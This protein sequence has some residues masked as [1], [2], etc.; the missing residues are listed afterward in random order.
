[1]PELGALAEH[2]RGLRRAAGVTYTELALRT[3][4]SAAHLKR[5]ASGKSLPS[6]NLVTAYATAC[7]GKPGFHLSAGGVSAQHGRGGHQAGNAEGE[8]VHRPA[9]APARQGHRRSQRR[10]A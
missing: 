9:Q 1:M 8:P 6:L 2:L 7:A 5:A 4:Y 10:V 3:P